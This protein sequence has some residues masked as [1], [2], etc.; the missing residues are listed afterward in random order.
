MDPVPR[1]RHRNVVTVEVGV[2]AIIWL[3]PAHGTISSPEGVG[4]LSGLLL[5]NVQFGFGFPFDFGAVVPDAFG[6][7]TINGLVVVGIPHFTTPLEI[8]GSGV[9]RTNGR[10]RG[11]PIPYGVDF[12]AAESVPFTKVFTPSASASAADLPLVFV[13]DQMPSGRHPVQIAVGKR[14]LAGERSR[15]IARGFLNLIRFGV[16]GFDFKKGHSSES[17]ET[18]ASARV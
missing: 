10:G 5:S 13:V 2:D 9:R 16:S 17:V 18:K 7:F 14:S 8:G 3:W 6:L 4:K 11:V 12:A 1:M 15:N